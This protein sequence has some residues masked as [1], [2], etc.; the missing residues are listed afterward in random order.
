MARLR[1]A[2]API[3]CFTLCRKARSP[4]TDVS[5]LLDG[6]GTGDDA[7]TGSGSAS[8][9]KTIQYRQYLHI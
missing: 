7:T 1:K 2:Y 5:A 8:A 4:E 9:M 3:D 6:P